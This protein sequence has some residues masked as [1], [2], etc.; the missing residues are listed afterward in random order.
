V[1]DLNTHASNVI[2]RAQ[3]LLEFQRVARVYWNSEHAGAAVVSQLHR[4]E[5]GPPR[6][7]ISCLVA[8][9]WMPGRTIRKVGPPVDLDASFFA[10]LL[11]VR[12][13]AIRRRAE[14]RA[15]Q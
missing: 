1:R 4:G 3:A 13:S 12:G 9:S 5:T 15:A 10:D 7:A 14:Q 11:Q 6:D 8:G 2:I